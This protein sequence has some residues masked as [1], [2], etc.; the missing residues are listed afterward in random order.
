MEKDLIKLNDPD[1]SLKLLYEMQQ[2]NKKY[3]KE[4]LKEMTKEK[5][6]KILEELKQGRVNIV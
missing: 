1:G 5:D 6:L 3:E 4:I 2:I